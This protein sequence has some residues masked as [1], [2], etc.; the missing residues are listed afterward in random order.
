[1]IIPQKI[2]FISGMPRSGT[3]ITRKLYLQMGNTEGFPEFGQLEKL[4]NGY[5]QNYQGK[6]R[7]VFKEPNLSFHIEDFINL[8]EFKSMDIIF[9]IRP[10]EDI[11]SSY[12]Q[13]YENPQDKW[14][15]N[16]YDF[17]NDC[18]NFFNTVNNVSKLKNK[19]VNVYFL[20]YKFIFNSLTN[21]KNTCRKLEIMNNKKANL[22]FKRKINF[23]THENNMN[24][25]Q[26][27]KITQ[28]INTQPDNIKNILSFGLS[29]SEFDIIKLN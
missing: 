1:M 12:L 15:R 7:V 22:Y 21:F 9:L 28:K 17:L 2:I 24:Q 16:E 29:D 8:I 3:T 11:L 10:Y 20:S 23:S 18:N 13:R 4:I 6:E 25:E 26:I 14:K 5:K 19:N 27:D